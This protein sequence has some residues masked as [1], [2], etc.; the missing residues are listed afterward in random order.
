M[1]L[2]PYV[3]IVA[4]GKGRARAMTLAEAQDAMALILR[5]DAAPKRSA[6]C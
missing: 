6:R 1:S 2:A 3:R 5:G 4:R